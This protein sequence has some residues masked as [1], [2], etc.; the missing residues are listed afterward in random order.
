MFLLCVLFSITTGTLES[1]GLISD[2]LADSLSEKKRC[3]I[4]LSTCSAAARDAEMQAH[5]EI[6]ESVLQQLISLLLACSCVLCASFASGL[7]VGLACVDQD[8]LNVLAAVTLDNVTLPEERLKLIEEKYMAKQMLSV[9]SDKHLLLVTLILINSVANEALPLFLD[10]IFSKFMACAVSV[11]LVIFVS[12]ILPITIFTGPRQIR[13]ASRMVPVV[14]TLMFACYPLTRPVASLLDRLVK[15]DMEKAVAAETAIQ[16]VAQEDDDDNMQNMVTSIKIPSI[17]LIWKT[18]SK[19]PKLPAK[20]MFSGFGTANLPIEAN[21]LVFDGASVKGWISAQDLAA[22]HAKDGDK[23][24]ELFNL[25]KLIFVSTDADDPNAFSVLKRMVSQNT[26]FCICGDENYSIGY[27][28][29]EH[30]LKQILSAA[31]EES[32]IEVDTTP[33]VSSPKT[34]Q[35]CFNEQHQHGFDNTGSRR[36]K[37]FG[38][39]RMDSCRESGYEDDDLTP[40]SCRERNPLNMK[41]R[42]SAI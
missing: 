10:Q 7:T 1:A 40:N 4:C 36:R 5:E 6:P 31:E 23:L 35:E 8:K 33:R 38:F 42:S 2:S 28:S 24:M 15:A 17:K 21:F 29:K 41:R 30:V 39:H 9:V 11:T 12:E 25:K 32:D 22:E 13:V 27:V 16:Q 19:V 37:K 20:D 14:R 18:F 34:L 3:E 26:H